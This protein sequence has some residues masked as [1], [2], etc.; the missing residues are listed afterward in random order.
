MDGLPPLEHVK[1]ARSPDNRIQFSN[2]KVKQLVQGIEAARRNW[3]FPNHDF[4]MEP[5]PLAKVTSP[6]DIS[7]DVLKTVLDPHQAMHPDALE[8]EGC[9]LVL[10]ELSFQ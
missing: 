10:V 6:A 7:I 1:P 2:G 8:H 4:N 5:A 3:Q 9:L